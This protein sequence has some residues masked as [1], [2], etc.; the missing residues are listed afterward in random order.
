MKRYTY[1][2]EADP[3]LSL[4]ALFRSLYI[5]NICMYA[6]WYTMYMHAYTSKGLQP[7]NSELLRDRLYLST[8]NSSLLGAS[9]WP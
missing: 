6:T 4:S 5:H 2:H 7:R 1:M 8:Q 9:T 3:S